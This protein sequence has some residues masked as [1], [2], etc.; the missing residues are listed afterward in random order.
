MKIHI[1]E[2][3]RILLPERNYNIVERGKI[4]VKG[5][6]TMKTYFVLNKKNENGE[7]V[8]CPFMSL[9]EEFKKTNISIDDE[10]IVQDEKHEGFFTS[11]LRLFF[12]YNFTLRFELYYNRNLNFY[13]TLKLVIILIFPIVKNQKQTWA[14]FIKYKSLS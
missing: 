10:F 7:A 4:E 11:K 14:A 2:A 1:S 3:T 8:V 5:K 12:F 6:G 9:M 13:F